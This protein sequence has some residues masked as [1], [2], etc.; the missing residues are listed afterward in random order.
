MHRYIESLESC[1]LMDGGNLD[2][3]FGTKGSFERTAGQDVQFTGTDLDVGPH[4][5]ILV[6]STPRKPANDPNGETL[7]H[8]WKPHASGATD[9]KFG[10]NGEVALPVPAD[11]Y[12]P[13]SVL[14]PSP[15]SSVI[16]TDGSI[17]VAVGYR[18]FKF[19]HD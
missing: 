8:L 7:I 16:T 1:R 17:F 19:R 3:A 6:T 13:A 4:G 9:V 10:D 12:A 11:V 14:S 18:L 5:E 2:T 15:A